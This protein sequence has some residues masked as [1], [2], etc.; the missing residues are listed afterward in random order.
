M[1]P[2]ERIAIWTILIVL[3]FTVFFKVTSGFTAKQTNLMTL[4][5]FENVP[6][7]VKDLYA[8]AMTPVT[9]AAAGKVKEFWGSL[10]N[11]QKKAFKT[12]VM[13]SSASM[14][15][16]IISIDA[17]GYVRQLMQPRQPA[18]VPPMGIPPSVPISNVF[19]VP[20]SN[21]FAV[22][23]SNVYSP[24]PMAMKLY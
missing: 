4:A 20:M 3:V 5:E 13:N 19:A 15:S 21:V 17:A 1:H 24:A 10:N 14:T 6:S 9:Q 12:E 23:M 7:E 2:Y 16:Q 11:D 8:S 18:P 22:P